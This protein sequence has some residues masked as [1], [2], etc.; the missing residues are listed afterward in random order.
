MKTR[1]I[2]LLTVLA[3]ASGCSEMKAAVPDRA[4]AQPYMTP[5]PAP[6][7]QIQYPQQSKVAPA[8]IAPLLH[9]SVKQRVSEWYWAPRTVFAQNTMVYG[10][11]SD[12]RLINRLEFWTNGSQQIY[13]RQFIVHYEKLPSGFESITVLRYKPGPNN[14]DLYDGQTQ[15]LSSLINNKLYLARVTLTNRYQQKV[16]ELDVDWTANG[17]KGTIRNPNPGRFGAT[18]DINLKATDWLK[19]NFDLW[20]EFGLRT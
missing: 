14:V 17:V 7:S 16:K 9:E 3:L 8:Q 11:W 5:P 10:G 15:Y 18:Q 20:S 1:N 6:V 19:Q 13:Q 4:P 12:G 2:A